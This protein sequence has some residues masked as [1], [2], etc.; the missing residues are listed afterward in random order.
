MKN[1]AFKEMKTHYVLAD[2]KGID[3]DTLY[4]TYLPLFQPVPNTC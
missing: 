1:K 3:W 2:Y 4:E